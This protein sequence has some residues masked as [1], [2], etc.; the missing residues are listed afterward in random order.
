MT[1]PLVTAP[2]A[3]LEGRTAS[4]VRLAALVATGA[5]FESYAE[6]VAQA[7]EAQASVDEVIGVLLT[8]APIVGLART[9]SA[10]PMLSLALGYDVDDAFERLDVGGR[11]PVSDSTD[12]EVD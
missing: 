6:V 5:T 1:E 9:V 2:G 4:L 11:Q 7:L 10:T 12:A 3:R 8:V